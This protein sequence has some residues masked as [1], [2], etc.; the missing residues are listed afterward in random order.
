[1]H[2]F[3]VQPISI[4]HKAEALFI[5]DCSLVNPEPISIDIW[6]IGIVNELSYSTEGPGVACGIG[7]KKLGAKLQAE[8]ITNDTN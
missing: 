7:M 2:R 1:M 5:I 6:I 4:I 8:Q 3:I